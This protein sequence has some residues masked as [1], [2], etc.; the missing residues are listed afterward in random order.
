MMRRKVTLQIAIIVMVI[1]GLAGCSGKRNA[2]SP[3]AETP[4]ESIQETSEEQNAE[5]DF[6]MPEELSEVPD[7]EEISIDYPFE[8]SEEYT[9][10]LA[11]LTDS[12][13]EYELK[14]YGKDR[15]VLQQIPCGRLVEPI[16][17]SYDGLAYHTKNNLEIFSSE[18]TTGFL[19]IW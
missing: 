10:T 12:A 14:L 2:A 13:D 18:S 7:R 9:L 16:E 15:E 11:K 4:A 1:L 3:E 8:D 19:F 17:F 5:T 6:S